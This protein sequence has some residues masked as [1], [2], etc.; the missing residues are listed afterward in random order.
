MTLRDLV[1]TMDADE[2]LVLRGF[3]ND[4]VLEITPDE[5]INEYEILHAYKVGH[6]WLSRN[7]YNAIVI[8][9]E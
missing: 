2:K 8:D 3:D 9:L 7:L 6:I 4:E 1:L 5:I